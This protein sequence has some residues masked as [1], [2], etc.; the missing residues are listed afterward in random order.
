MAACSGEK[1]DDG[2]ARLV[3]HCHLP[4]REVMTGIGSVPVMPRVHDRKPCADRITLALS[5]L[6]RYLR[7]A[8][9]V[10]ELLPQLYLKGM[11]TGDLTEALEVLLHPDT[12]GLSATTIT[13]LKADW[14][15]DFETWQKLDLSIRRLLYIW[16]RIGTC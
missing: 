15:T 2:R 12:K 9:S 10:E 1:L 7:K 8:K 11:S 14:R 5:I 16:S 13:R 6:P 4:E 3:C